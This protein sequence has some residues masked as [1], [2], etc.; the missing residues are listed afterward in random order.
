MLFK[1]KLSSYER[2]LARIERLHRKR[3]L[4]HQRP[5]I[6]FTSNDYLALANSTR[7]KNAIKAAI[8]EGVAVG[9]GG[10]RVLRGNHDVFA[11]L[12]AHAA[13][14][15]QSESA[16]YFSSGYAANIAIFATLPRARDFIL[17]DEYVHAS[18]HDGIRASLAKALAFRHNDIEDIVTKI[19]KWRLQGGKGRPWIAVESLYSMEGDR[20]P[21]AAI[22]SFI[23]EYDGFLV[24]DE[25]HATGVF[26][27]HGQ[28][29]AASFAGR[30]NIIRMH[31]CGKALGVS[32]ALIS[33]N[34][35]FVDYLINRARTFIY[36]TAPSPLSAVAV[37]EALK[38]LNDEPKRRAKLTSLYTFANKEISMHSN[39]N[40][41]GS[42]IIPIEIGDNH[43]T[44]RIAA[45]MQEQGFDL[46][47]IRPPTVPIGRSRLRIAITLH[48]SENEIKR[49]WRCLKTSIEEAKQ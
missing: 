19:K 31:T 49:M 44:L 15:F 37:N 22:I 46:R 43:L 10:S 26:G 27:S 34:K 3:T 42:Q 33:T 12:E 1:Q 30:D 14:F 41:N 17:Y 13:H 20:S 25:S 11:K 4:S 2:D 36:S 5:S 29:L 23:D 39:I 21:L 40:G 6:D 24:I 7:L 28:G 18:M 35:I 32:G 48:V 16:L 8:D 47:A 9:A 45:R 38:I